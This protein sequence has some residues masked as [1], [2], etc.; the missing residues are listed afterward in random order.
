MDPSSEHWPVIMLMLRIVILTEYSVHGPSEHW[1]VIMLMFLTVIL[2]EHSVHG[3]VLRTLAGH[4]ADVPVESG[5][6]SGPRVLGY[7]S[8]LSIYNGGETLA[9]EAR[10]KEREDMISNVSIHRISY[11]TKRNEPLLPTVA[12]QH[13]SEYF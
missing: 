6:P 13:M 4:N 11:I 8:T 10:L 3:P 12:L 7:D 5:C 9:E 2:T 1:P